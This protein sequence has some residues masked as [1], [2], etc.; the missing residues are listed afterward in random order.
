MLCIWSLTRL[1]QVR[2][3]S[4]FSCIC[5]LYN[6]LH[7]YMQF[8]IAKIWTSQNCLV[9]KM[10]KVSKTCQTALRESSTTLD[11]KVLLF[12]F[13]FSCSTKCRQRPFCLLKWRIFFTAE[14]PIRGSLGCRWDVVITRSNFKSE[15]IFGFLSPNY[16]GQVTWYF[17]V[18]RKHGIFVRASKIEL[19]NWDE[20][21]NSDACYERKSSLLNMYY[22]WKKP[23]K[24]VSY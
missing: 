11:I 2:L 18:K 12:F 4:P 9:L 19:N 23:R 22:F 6:Y 3:K 15:T 5:I 24:D 16:M 14:L 8:I 7:T 10:E 17:L 20:L 21:H 1:L 13:N